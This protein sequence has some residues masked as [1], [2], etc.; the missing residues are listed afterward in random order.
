MQPR[1]RALSD[2]RGGSRS[3]SN[4]T[5]NTKRDRL[6]CYRCGEYDHFVQ[7]CPNM[8]KD[9]EMGHSDSEQAS[10]QMLTQDSLPLNSNGD[11]E[12]SNL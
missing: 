1:S 11:V 5:V 6:R 7:E 8:P 9:D 2:D 10:L 3:T 4:S 12:Y